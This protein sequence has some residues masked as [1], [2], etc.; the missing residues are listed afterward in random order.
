MR[1][2]PDKPK[3]FFHNVHF[4]LIPH[5]S[6]HII[7]KAREIL[8]AITLDRCVTDTA[9]VVAREWRQEG[10][11]GLVNARAPETP[12]T[13]GTLR[14][15]STRFGALEVEE[16]IVITFAEGLIGFEECRR[17]AVVHQEEGSAFRWLQSLDS[18]ALAFPIIEP[19]QIRPDYAPTMSDADGRALELTTDTPT[20]LFA[21]VTVPPR[22][23]QAM[24]VNLLGPLVVNAETRRGKQ[25][26]VLDEGVTTRHSV[27]EE[28]ARAASVVEN[29]PEGVSGKSR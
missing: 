5:S 18:P 14:V 11:F 16:D 2:E 8:M 17:Y 26:I 1:D 21:I 6:S 4:E 20:L 7:N 27:V 3:G 24:T 19:N 29:R 12:A 13:G 15:E 9:L 22:E 10:V 23:P 28:L 25:V